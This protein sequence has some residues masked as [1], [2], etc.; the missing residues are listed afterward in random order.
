MTSSARSTLE[1]IFSRAD[2]F[3][4]RTRWAAIWSLWSI[5]VLG[6][7]LIDLYLV[8]DL[9][10]NRGRF[11]I[12]A[13]SLAEL[14]SL[15][16]SKLTREPVKEGANPS[17]HE[18]SFRN[19]GLLPVLWSDR[20]RFWAPVLKSLYQSVPLLRNDKQALVALLLTGGVLSL[21]WN[22][23]ST[24]ARLFHQR[25]AIDVATRLRKSL[26]R[27]VLRLGPSDLVG[28]E[29]EQALQLFQ[30]DTDTIRDGIWL[31][32]DGFWR[33]RWLLGLLLVLPLLL[34]PV[35]TLQCLIPLAICFWLVD[36]ARGQLISAQ[37]AA[38]SRSE[39]DLRLLAESLQKTRL[40]RG[41]SMENFEQEQF[42]RRL[43]RYQMEVS[44]GL[45]ARRWVERL[46]T[47]LIC[48]SIGLVL[49]LIGSKILFEPRELTCAAGGL[50]MLCLGLCWAPA[51][52]LWN[53][54]REL[55]P[56]NEAAFRVQ[57]YLSKIPEVGQAVGARFLQP[58]AKLLEF[59]RVSYTLADH[60]TLLK[61]FSLRIP[62]GRQLAMISTDP[63]E[64]RAAAFLLP[65][66]IEPQS[67]KVLFD[68]EDIAWVTL[69]SLRA[70]TSF[71]G[72][73]DPFLTG[74][75]AQNISGGDSRFGLQE[76]TDAAKLVHAH[77]FISRLPLG[78][79]TVVGEHGESLDP[80]QA[81]RLGLARAVIRKP[82]LL[83]I[84]EPD[85][86][87]DEDTKH[88]LDDAYKRIAP[89]R[90]VLFLASR[91]T[92]LRRVDEIVFIHKGQVEAVG[93]RQ[94]LAQTCPLYLHWEYM[95]FNEFRHELD[96]GIP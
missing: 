67:G 72:G 82:A 79:E 23:A 6:L 76:I 30:T 39:Q 32:A 17:A 25:V 94:R 90:T 47:A 18:L 11:S 52:R 15:A 20:N 41:Y 93:P 2:L 71:V 77:Q 84:E 8:M 87:L 56:A 37:R 22:R 14:E 74:T 19:R 68:G 1:Q 27:Q 12:P 80:G 5:L 83:I 63:L 49:F 53:L 3:R 48:L 92:T 54:P 16:G 43:D 38:Q 89:G 33:D 96:A 91:L 81:F 21:M 24:R 29:H 7:L 64:S 28:H 13:S 75:I 58:L 85:A 31:W 44:K 35:L 45:S 86:A 57:T 61:E 59:D 26:H 55:M 34:A 60:R 42:Q 40:V 95:H 51:T 70:E 69:E 65:R 88:L 46:V 78:Y 10:S 66:F 36:R 4:G 73:R 62:A 50:L 9:L